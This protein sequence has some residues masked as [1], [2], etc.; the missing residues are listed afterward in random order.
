MWQILLTKKNSP[1]WL[2]RAIFKGREEWNEIASDLLLEGGR[3]NR[4]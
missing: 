4:E 3:F 2:A 1:R